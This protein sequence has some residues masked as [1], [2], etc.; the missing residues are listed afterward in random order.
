M[1]NITQLPTLWPVSLNNL[2]YTGF[3]NSLLKALN[4]FQKNAEGGIFIDSC[5]VHCQTWMDHTWHSP[6]S[7]RINNKVSKVSECDCL[8]MLPISIFTKNFLYDYLE[9]ST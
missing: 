3:R 6:Q 7:P 1:L 4:E 2:L 5:F 8:L 9:E